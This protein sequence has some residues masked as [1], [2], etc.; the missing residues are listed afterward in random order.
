VTEC[1]WWA[2]E[3]YP[4][5]TK[6]VCYLFQA[7]ILVL[8]IHTFN[9]FYSPMCIYQC[10]TMAIHGTTSLWQRKS[11]GT[12][13]MHTCTVEQVQQPVQRDFTEETLTLN[14]Y[15]FPKI[16]RLF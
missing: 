11:V 8:G 10:V 14:A 16:V 5:Q 2:P 6:T 3:I 4:G 15:M 9:S 1:F 12:H 7:E 13:T